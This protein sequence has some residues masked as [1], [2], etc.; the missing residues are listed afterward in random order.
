MRVDV[1]DVQ[2]ERNGICMGLAP[3]VFHLTED[4]ELE[5][6]RPEVADDTE[7]VVREAVRRCPRQAIS[8]V[9]EE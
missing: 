8:I 6:L 5:V 7:G 1:D 4:D 3:D 9:G 2:C